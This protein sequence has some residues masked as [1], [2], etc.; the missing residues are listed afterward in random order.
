MHTKHPNRDLKPPRIS[1]IPINFQQ[2]NLN[3]IPGL[4]LRISAPPLLLYLSAGHHHTR[5]RAAAVCR[6]RRCSR[7]WTCSDHVDE[8]IPSVVNSSGL[9]VRADE[10]VLFP[11]VDR[12]RRSTAA[13]R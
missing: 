6:R 11:A 2:I 10:G 13:Y 1:K 12:I 9:L 5:R 8:E 7:D 4:T 3:H